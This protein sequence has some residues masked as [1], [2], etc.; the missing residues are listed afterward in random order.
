MVELFCNCSN[1]FNVE[2]LRK[3]IALQ[4]FKKKSL[5]DALR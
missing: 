3:F 4:D 5:V 2:V 1:D